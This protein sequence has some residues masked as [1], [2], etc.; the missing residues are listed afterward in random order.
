MNE[1][2]FNPPSPPP[3]EGDADRLLDLHL[4]ALPRFEPTPGFADRVMARVTIR[5]PVA[6]VQPWYARPLSGRAGALAAGLSGAAAL[7][8]TALT[9]WL[10]PNVGGLA[11]GAG[12]LAVG[13]SLAAWQAFLAWLPQASAS[14]GAAL[15][16]IVTTAGPVPVVALAAALTL[17]IPFSML[18]LYLATRPPVR[19]RMVP[20]AAR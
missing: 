5:R 16:A 3:P 1:I 14:A 13:T 7:T 15:V 17:S 4:A 10:V 6:A 11:A 19:S 9:A 2:P 20:H 8:S 18:G 12:S